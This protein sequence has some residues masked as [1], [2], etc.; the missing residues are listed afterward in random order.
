MPILV[1]HSAT[2][3]RSVS[4]AKVDVN[5]FAGDVRKFSRE[6]G[7]VVRAP[8]PNEKDARLLVRTIDALEKEVR[9]LRGRIA[10]IPAAPSRHSRAG[11]NPECH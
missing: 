3:S 5:A 4:K 2:P 10:D 9:L 1:V 8:L 6:V 7:R 11:G